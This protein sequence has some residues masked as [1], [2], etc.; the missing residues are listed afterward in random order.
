[1]SDKYRYPQFNGFGEVSNTNAQ[2]EIVASPGETMYAYIEHM[3]FSIHEAAQ[4]GGG[5]LR[6]QDSNGN[7]I[8]ETD[9][10]GVKAEPI[11]LGDEGIRIGPDA[12]IHAVVYGAGSKQ[13][14]ATVAVTGHLSFR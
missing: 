13:A 10:N 1:M 6:L 8:W 3:A 7:K 12:G 9:A 2:V 11:P 5:K 4:G 14:T